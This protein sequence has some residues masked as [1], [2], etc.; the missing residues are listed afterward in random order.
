MAEKKKNSIPDG[1]VCSNCLQSE[2]SAGVSKLSACSRCG[3]VLYCSRDCQKAHWKANHKQRCIAKADRA[4]G[5]LHSSGTEKEPTSSAGS[6]GEKCSIC[7]DPLTDASSTTTLPC[8]HVFHGTCVAELRKLGVKQVCPLCRV[9][10]PPGAGKD[11][12]D[13]TLRYSVVCCLVEQGRLSWSNLPAQMARDMKAVIKVWQ[14]AANGGNLEAQHNLG[15]MFSNGQSVA[16][17]D[18][19][20]AQ[21]FRKAAELGHAPAQYSLGVACQNGDGVAQSD[22]EAAQWYRKA[23]DQGQLEAQG[24]LGA[25]HKHG[26]GVTQSAKEA[27]YWFRKAADQGDVGAQFNL[28]RM[29]E[30]GYGGTQ[31]NVEAARWFKRA[32]D[33]GDAECQYEMGNCHQHG[34]G[35]AQS[36]MEAL[37]WYRKAA[38]QG[39]APAQL[40]MGVACELGCDGVSQSNAEAAKWFKKAANQG[41]ANAKRLLGR[42]SQKS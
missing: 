15:V 28:A 34:R 3:L 17:S 4:P 42:L 19:K 14:A 26:F 31:S 6:T 2:G 41:N 23:A 33:Q 35:V 20:A 11:F 10:L 8:T 13:A 36:D 29:Y 18:A 16:Q 32:A 22:V 39:F 5:P 21:W 1:M 37:R 25:M 7:L 40:V 30:N 38:D 12:E 24:N 9:P 27:V